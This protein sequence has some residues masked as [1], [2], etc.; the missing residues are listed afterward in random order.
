MRI[1]TEYRSFRNCWTIGSSYDVHAHQ[2]HS[3]RKC[4]SLTALQWFRMLPGLTSVVPGLSSVRPGMWWAHSGISSALPGAPRHF[5]DAP[6]RVA[7]ALRCTQACCPCSQVLP[8]L[9]RDVLCPHRFVAGARRCSWRPLHPSCELW[10]W[11]TL[12]FWSDNS[13]TLPDAPRDKNASCLW[14]C[15]EIA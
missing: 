7:G 9:S 4:F 13:Q 5:V 3:Q 12:R 11:S 15:Q 6:R 14:E 10:D 1:Q 2:Q 8:W